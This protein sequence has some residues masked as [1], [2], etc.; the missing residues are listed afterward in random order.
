[1]ALGCL[2]SADPPPWLHRMRDLGYPPGYMC[3]Q[4]PSWCCITILGLLCKD[5]IYCHCSQIHQ[6]YKY[7][8]SQKGCAAALSLCGPQSATL[9][10]WKNRACLGCPCRALEP[11]PREHNGLVLLDDTAEQRGD[12]WGDEHGEVGLDSYSSQ[13]EGT[14]APAQRQLVAIPGINA[15]VPEDADLEKWSTKPSTLYAKVHILHPSLLVHSPA[16]HA[17]MHML[18]YCAALRHTHHTGLQVCWM[19]YAC[20][21]CIAHKTDYLAT[22]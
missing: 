15:P 16:G 18:V 1:M 10:R 19:S 13:I 4:S 14:V 2:G 5:C 11:E 7:L 9:E 6:H 21:A 20:N 12:V 17:R 3:A 8:S 22:C